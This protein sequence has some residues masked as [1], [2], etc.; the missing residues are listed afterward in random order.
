MESFLLAHDGQWERTEKG[1]ILCTITGHEV[2]PSLPDLEAHWRGKAFK[3]GLARKEN[4]EYD[5]EKHKPYIVP[6]RFEEG[7]LYCTLTKKTL[8]KDHKEVIAHCNGR[9]YKH[10]ITHSKAYIAPDAD[11]EDVGRLAMMETLLEESDG[12]AA[13]ECSASSSESE[14]DEH[15]NVAIDASKETRQVKRKRPRTKEESV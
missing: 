11:E 8:N 4:G 13:S 14:K 15:K 6:H 3:R 2:A 7:K 10:A 5:F 9:H 12:E 1:K